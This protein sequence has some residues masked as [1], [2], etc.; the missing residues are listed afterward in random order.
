MGGHH[1]VECRKDVT[2]AEVVLCYVCRRRLCFRHFDRLRVDGAHR[3]VCFKDSQGRELEPGFLALSDE[4]R[5]RG[6][7]GS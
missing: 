2:E 1:C 6:R 4:R 3:L 5:A 7:E